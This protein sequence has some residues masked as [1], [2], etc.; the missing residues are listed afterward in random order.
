[1]E[2]I[3]LALAFHRGQEELELEEEEPSLPLLASL[4]PHHYH[5]HRCP[6]YLHQR[7]HQICSEP[8]VS[9]SFCL[10]RP[11]SLSLHS[12]FELELRTYHKNRLAALAATLEEGATP[13]QWEVVV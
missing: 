1:V 5:R 12:M 3:Y 6:R 11:S 7:K 4:C 13:S 10:Q 9:I 8:F 2:A